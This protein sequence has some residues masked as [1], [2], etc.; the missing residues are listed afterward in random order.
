MISYTKH[1][2][3]SKEVSIDCQG[4]HFLCICGSHI[5]GGYVANMKWGVVAELSTSG[6]DDGY[7]CEKNAAALTHSPLAQN[8]PSNPN[9]RQA[10]GYECAKFVGDV[11]YG[12]RR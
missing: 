2:A 1:T 7:N 11:T 8:L 6:A 5:N 4:L 10:R 3:S 9:T 12:L